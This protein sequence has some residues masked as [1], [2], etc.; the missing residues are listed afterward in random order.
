MSQPLAVSLQLFLISA[1]LKSYAI[2]CFEGVD[3]CS[4]I[5]R[6]AETVFECMQ[7]RN[8]PYTSIEIILEIAFVHCEQ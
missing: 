7:R 2:I 8:L 6:S 4:N 5:S 1:I 3:R